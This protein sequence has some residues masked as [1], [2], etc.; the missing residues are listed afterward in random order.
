MSQGVNELTATGVEKAVNGL[1]SMLQLTV[2]GVE[3]IIVFVI[4]MLTSTYVC[5]ITLAVSGSL[6]AALSVVED[7]SKFL[8]QTLDG[9]GDDLAGIAS[10]FT[11]DLNKFVDTLNSIPFVNNKVPTLNITGDVDKLK[12]LQIP[13]SFTDDLQSINSSIP[14]FEDVHNF[15]NSL[16]RLPF[17]KIKGLI[18][19]SMNTYEFNRS[20]FPVPARE[21]LSFCT[22]DNGI[23]EFFDG[24]VDLEHLAKK[25]FIA[26]ILILAI[27]VCAPMAW[28]EIKRWRVMRERAAL[29]N[30][31]ASDPMDVVY[32]AS[33]P[34][35]AG[36][37]IKF[38]NKFRSIREQKVVRW[39]VA[40][41]TS[42]PALF[43]LSLGIAGL[44]ACLCQYILLQAIRKEV[45]E[46]T[47]QV[48][49][50][51]EKV[52]T[53]L[54]NA[55]EQWAIGTN[56]AILDTND[57]INQDL[58]GW[59]NTSTVAVNDTLNSFVDGMNEELTKVFG[60]TP[61]E[62]PVKD[63]IG[64]LITL[65]IVG[66]QKGLTWVHDNA[67][68]DFPLMPNDTFSLGALASVTDSQDDDQFLATPGSSSRD[69]IT[70]AVD[71]L[72]NALESGIR[73]EAIISACIIGIWFIAVLVGLF[74]L[75]L[76]MARPG[77]LRGEGGD[78]Y[79]AADPTS[80]NNRESMAPTYEYAMTS[81]NKRP[82]YTLSPRPF[83]QFDNTEKVRDVGA[84]N[85]GVVEPTH[86]RSSSYGHMGGLTPI[87]EKPRDP[88]PDH[89]RG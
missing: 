5:L 25:V 36:F 1:M 47:N 83:P 84:Y 24:L 6:R 44:F 4:N 71:K 69:D 81:N 55:S 75:I 64:C 88:F 40:Y 27:A 73:T 43:V 16:I 79:Y 46:L 33:R 8:N 10:S 70:A 62:Q 42:P 74:R 59:V 15:T 85:P 14:D 11:T 80:T 32:I 31:Q 76:A 65:K 7:V 89:R 50:F 18:N 21:K 26:V 51:A 2:T 52:V 49:G 39:S 22:G 37:G 45:P 60:G 82:S 66:I 41:A 34:H 56:K 63:I 19:E 87:D 86:L 35:T 68:I 12:N 67:H 72:T 58:F 78:A 20:V 77:K 38:A 23:N 28:W 57:K 53:S 48:S 54:N 61:L 9:I 30:Q 13:S 17:E 29:V 3:E